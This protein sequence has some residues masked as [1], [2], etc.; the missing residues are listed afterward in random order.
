LDLQSNPHFKSDGLSEIK[1]SGSSQYSEN[2]FKQFMK[3]IKARDPLAEV[4]L[5]DLQHYDHVLVNG[6]DV[7]LL[8]T[9]AE[10]ISDRTAEEIKLSEEQLKQAILH[11]R[12]IRLRALDTLY[13]KDDYHERFSYDVHPEKVET[14]EEFIA[15]AGAHYILIPTKRFSEI[16]DDTEVD[17]LV[18]HV[19]TKSE[20]VWDHFHCKMGK[21]RTTLYLAMNDILYNADKL[22]MR[23]IVKR[24]HLMGGIDLF[25]VTPLDQTW[26]YEK[27]GKI[28]RVVF[29]ARFHE[30]AK[31]VFLPAKIAHAVPQSWSD[32]SR[33]HVGFQPTVNHLVVDKSETRE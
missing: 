24:Q 2:S 6:M 27:Q 3:D 21:S 9:N 20:H 14:P 19:R 28:D 4:F 26:A 12:G 31:T 18:D 23:D 1:A 15:R 33:V 11:E 8:E 17:R 29:L 7:S 5:W 32:W 13:P 10:F 30:Y 25:D 16:S 22:S